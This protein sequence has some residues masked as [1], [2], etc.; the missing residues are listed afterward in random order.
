[1]KYY[2]TIPSESIAL[3]SNPYM[4]LPSWAL[5]VSSVYDLLPTV[6]LELV[7]VLE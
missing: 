4:V 5:K 6:S 7:A 1:M 2:A 3:S